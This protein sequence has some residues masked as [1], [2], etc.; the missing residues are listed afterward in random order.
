MGIR[1]S[2]RVAS[3]SDSVARNQRKL[4]YTG[5]LRGP[6][7]QASDVRRYLRNEGSVQS[8]TGPVGEK[9][10]FSMNRLDRRIAVAPMMDCTDEV[11][12]HLKF[13][14]LVPLEKPYRLYVTSALRRSR[15]GRGTIRW[16]TVRFHH[17]PILLKEI[18][19]AGDYW[20]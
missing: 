4:V 3:A 1:R 5:V 6:M 12:K 18:S 15:G 2:L 7:I 17:D 8:D 10:S 16:S 13:N 11:K 19:P 9:K 14:R 20:L